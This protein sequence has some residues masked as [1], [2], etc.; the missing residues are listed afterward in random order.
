MPLP[1]CHNC[2]KI[3]HLQL[4]CKSHRTQCSVKAQY[5]SGNILETQ[6]AVDDD[7][8]KLFTVYSAQDKADGISN[9]FQ[10]NGQMV[11]MQLDTGASVFNPRVYLY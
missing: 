2:G 8:F 5:V 7:L 11:S 9:D 10:L 4:A 3:G 1:K 6:C